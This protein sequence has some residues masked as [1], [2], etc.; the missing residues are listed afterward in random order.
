MKN[1]IDLN[2]AIIRGESGGKVLWQPRIICWYDDRQFNNTPLPAPYTGMDLPELYEALG[3]SNRIYE[4][5]SAIKVIEDKSIKRYS[6]K[7]DDLRTEQ[8]IETPE[9]TI[10]AIIRKNTS[11]PGE[12]FDKWWI[13]NQKDMEVQ[14]YI[15]AHQDYEFSKEEFDRI[16][17]NGEITVSAVSISR[18]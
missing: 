9:G 3:C 17:K 18:E 16:Y 2:R 15:E 5:T 14:M 12:F 8:F 10:S 1:H 4:Y 7:I 6:K 11:N 13:E